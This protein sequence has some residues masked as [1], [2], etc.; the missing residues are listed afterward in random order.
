M[1]AADAS[2]GV[3]LPDI[4]ASPG[5]RPWQEIPGP[6]AMPLLGSRG[7]LIQ[8]LRDPI[9][10]M[11]RLH[12]AYGALAS[13]VQAQPG[14][15]FAFGPEYNRLILSNPGIFHSTGLTMPGPED[16]AQRRVGR[17]LL[18][19]N[20]AEHQ[21]Y[22]TLVLP[23]FHP[24]YIDTYRDAIVEIVDQHLAPWQ[25]GQTLDVWRAMKRLTL[26]VTTE[27]L[28]GLRPVERGLDL[29]RLME[30]WLAMNTWPSV[31]LFPQ[32]RPWSAFHRMLHQAERLEAAILAVIGERRTRPTGTTDILTLL[33]QARD[34]QG[35]A[36]TDAAL[37]GQINILFGAAHVTT[38]DSLT[39]TL[40]LLAQHPRICAA[41]VEELTGLLH[42]EAPRLDQFER[43]PLLDRVV[44]ESLR[45]LP[46][47]A[48]NCRLTTQ[49]VALGPY[50]LPARSTVAFSHYITHHLPELFPEPQV[51]RP[52][53]WLGAQPSAF[54]YIPFGA[55]PRSCIGEGFAKMTL[56]L[57]LS[58]ILQRFRLES[59]PGARIDRRVTITL[60]PK[61]GMSMRVHRQD[62]AFRRVPVRGN[63]HEMVDL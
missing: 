62:G 41:V 27:L 35:Q 44:K 18:S 52:D 19:I 20:D 55:G 30:R 40:F 34:D 33:L 6:A 37:V 39:W 57:T 61:G 54:A 25:P 51:F 47:P 21:Y 43:L 3:T 42:G 45:L 53:R 12:R 46:P 22:R 38:S 32:D 9:G 11:V 14:I 59:V 4:P 48:Y 49:P 23:L 5:G 15:I 36:L 29:G 2:A 24:R 8:F 7:N 28:F 63:I 13:F 10:Y 16:T 1:T 31:R 26:H 58:V 56:K 60:S 17:G 50:H